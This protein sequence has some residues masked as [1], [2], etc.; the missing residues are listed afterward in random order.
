MVKEPSGRVCILGFGREGRAVLAFLK[1]SGSAEK[2]SIKILDRSRDKDYLDKISKCKIVFRSPGVPFNLE[3]LKRA[4]KLG[5]EFSS[6]T[7][8]F[9]DN[10]KGRILGVTGTKGKG[11]TASLIYKILQLARRKAFLAGNIGSPALDFLKTTDRNSMAVLELSSFQLQDL[12][13]SPSIAVVLDVFPD[14]QDAHL[15]LKEYYRAK[16]NIGKFQKKQ[17]LIFF[18]QDDKNSSSI[19]KNSPAKKVPVSL[20]NFSLFSREDLKIRGEHNFK[21]AVM[22]SRVAMRLGIPK[23]VIIKAVKEFRGLP[24]RLEFVKT[25]RGVSFYDDSAS[26][27]PNTTIAALRSFPNQNKALIVGGQDKG[28]SYRELGRAIRLENNLRLLVLMGENK[29]KI[30][31]AVGRSCPTKKVA[32][33]NQAITAAYRAIVKTEGVVILS[34]GAASFDEFRDYADRGEKF[35]DLVRKVKI[36]GGN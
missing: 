8:L 6:G 17:D 1:R 33:L 28:L 24:H 34:P 7:Q 18:F 25:L 13:K 14:H 23:N 20:K 3:K 10:F 21:N 35:Q 4:R 27:N 2:S 22:A 16:S 11:T 19:V 12:K 5:V 9:F 29:N 36:E 30:A 32:S 26:T 31:A 15:N